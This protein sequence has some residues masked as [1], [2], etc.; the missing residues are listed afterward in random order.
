[1]HYCTRHSDERILH[2]HEVDNV[3]IGY[4]HTAH[5]LH[6]RYVRTKA[7][8]TKTSAFKRIQIERFVVF[9]SVER[10]GT[11]G[12]SWRTKSVQ[13]EKSSKSLRA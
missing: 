8:A 12:T 10:V 4:V 2:N 11:S 6:V 7:I 3:V 5:V 1:M 13:N 9:Y